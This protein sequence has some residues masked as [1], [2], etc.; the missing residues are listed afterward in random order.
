LVEQL[1]VA[2]GNGGTA[3]M[4]DVVNVPI[5]AS[6]HE[7]LITFCV[8]QGITCVVVSPEDP[9]V[10]GLADKLA[11]AEIACFGPVKAAA[12]LEGSKVFAKQVMNACA[13]R[14]ARYIVADNFDEACRIVRTM[15]YFVDKLVVK[16]DGLTGGKGVVVAENEVEAIAALESCMVKRIYGKAGDVVLIEE[17]LEGPELSVMLFCDGNTY[18]VMPA[19]Q[20]HKR[21]FDG[22]M[23]PNTGG[24]GA[25]SPVPIATPGV[26]EEIE[27][28]IISPLLDEL[29]CRG[30]VYRGIMYFGLMLT[31]D[32]PKV[33]EINCR[34]GDPETEVVLPRLKTDF[35]AVVLA[36]IQGTLD[37][38]DVTWSEQCVV[39]IVLASDGYP[40]SYEKGKLITGLEEASGVSG[41]EIFHA[42]TKQ[43]GT[44]ISTNGGRVLNVTARGRSFAEAFRSATKAAN[45]VTFDGKVR[46][47][48]IGFS[49]HGPVVV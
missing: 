2:P 46:R 47:N 42:G 20:D 10:A 26:M 13:V 11:E 43:V 40:E 6:D 27:A 15:F 34:G 16:P 1:Y 41:V 23:G 4:K 19:S 35:G 18:A 14:T 32:G 49:V 9:L 28:R 44:E 30:I 8:E 21:R 25:Y 38:L 45:V 36:C 48:D 7:T 24:M 17:C 33:L 3:L 29:K 12:M 31:K 37:Q 22:D 39:D 5:P